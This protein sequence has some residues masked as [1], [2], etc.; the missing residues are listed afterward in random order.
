MDESAVSL[1][2]ATWAQVF[3]EALRDVINP[4]QLARG[5]TIT[6]VAW[7]ATRLSRKQETFRK[8]KTTGPGRKEA[9]LFKFIAFWVI[10]L[11]IEGLLLARKAVEY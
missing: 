2:R 5:K 8:A 1:Q 4:H 9:V 7:K 10:I 11:S 6:P 3:S